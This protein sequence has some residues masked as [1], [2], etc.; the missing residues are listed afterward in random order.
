MSVDE[1]QL[2]IPPAACKDPKS[3]EILRLWAAGGKQHV[4]IHPHL[5]GG[6]E[7]FGFMVAQLARHGAILFS[8]RDNM[9]TD[10]A[11]SRIRIGFDDEW[12]EPQ[13]NATGEYPHDEQGI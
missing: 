10:E 2:D 3:F 7:G 5:K 13:G 9:P 1:H 4:T 8:Q 6:P 11:L 12:D